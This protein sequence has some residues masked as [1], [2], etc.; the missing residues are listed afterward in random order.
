MRYRCLFCN[1]GSK[2][3][4]CDHM[5]TLLP[6]PALCHLLRAESPD[7]LLAQFRFLNDFHADQTAIHTEWMWGVIKR[8]WWWGLTMCLHTCLGFLRG[9]CVREQSVEISRFLLGAYA[10][11]LSLLHRNPAVYLFYWS[12]GA[13]W[14]VIRCE[15]KHLPSA[16]VFWES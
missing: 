5:S 16:P 10:D 4:I 8:S 13:I 9:E 11:R 14:N 1:N 2:K 7:V 6:P 15:Y 12:K 3:Q